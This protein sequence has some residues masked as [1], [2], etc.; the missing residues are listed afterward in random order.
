MHKIK[1]TAK[2]LIPHRTAPRFVRK[3]ILLSAAMVSAFGVIAAQTA[4]A[5]NIENAFRVP[6]KDEWE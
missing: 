4:A 1:M 2:K 6:D 5:A 3:S